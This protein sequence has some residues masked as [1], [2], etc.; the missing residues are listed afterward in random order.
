M[1]YYF[2]V[3][4]PKKVIRIAAPNPPRL[5]G[6]E[7]REATAEEQ[8]Q[9]EAGQTHYTPTF[10]YNN[11][12]LGIGTL[13][14]PPAA[15]HKISKDTIIQRIAAANKVADA[16]ALYAAQS[17]ADKFLWDG[18]SWFWSDNQSIIGFA[19]A[20]GLDPAAVLARDPEL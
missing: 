18:S 10:D 5:V 16:A 15:R 20:L 17:D 8:A 9:I 6:Y 13:A 12:P 4:Q 14:A 1:K 3:S 7:I 2:P 11:K 19:G